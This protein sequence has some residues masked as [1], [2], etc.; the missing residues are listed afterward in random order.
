ML[1]TPGDPRFTAFRAGGRDR[2]AAFFATIAIVTV[3]YVGRD[4]FVPVAVAVLL[5]FVL[6]PVI[7]VLR[8]L[9][10]PRTPAVVGVVLVTFLGLFALGGV[11]ATQVTDLVADLPQYRVNLREK[12]ASVRDAAAGSGALER[13]MDVLQDLSREFEGQRP[14]PGG[15]APEMAV[16]GGEARPVPVEVRQ[17]P[18]GVFGTLSAVLAPLLRPLATFGIVFIF[19]LFILL[20]REDLRNRF[21]RLAGAHDIQRT[22]AALDDAAA[23]LSRFL[24]AQVAL[25]AAFGTV[26]GLGLF[27]I[28]LPSPFLWG[29]AA[30][31]LRFVPYVGAVIA[32]ALP[33]GLALAV[34]PGWSMVLST[35]ALFLVVEPLVG[36]VIE[37]LLYGRSTGLSPAAVIGAATFWTWLWGPVGLLLST[38]LTL[39]LV[40][41][42]R[43]VES[44]EFL[45]VALGDQPPLSDSELLYQRLLAGDPLEAAAAAENHLKEQAP[46]SY[47]DTVALPALRLAQSDA[48]RGALDGSRQARLRETLADMLDHLPEPEAMPEEGVPPA[49]VVMAARSPL[50]EAAGLLLSYVLAAEGIACEVRAPEMRRHGGGA[51]R[52]PDRGSGA[53]AGVEQAVLSYLSPATPAHRRYM[54]RR[55]AREHAGI[56][57][58]VADWAAADQPAGQRCDDETAVITTMQEALDAIRGPAHPRTE[59]APEPTSGPV[60]A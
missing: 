20:Q 19:L 5:A 8:R 30:A 34:D 18:P 29:L 56:A 17:P 31:V 51:G 42:G 52:G 39:C 47:C 55:L 24:L 9:G 7:L 6:A 4:V 53:R 44:L 45:D 21:I 25:N 15:A 11:L 38:P 22:T 35:A 16:A 60:P 1:Q 14:V 41:M 33:L 3:L 46:A 2:L 10:L 49:V 54:I 57:V 27:A 36:H 28:G 59:P 13:T 12:I 50:D 40:V 37:P 32:A 48:A 23:R 58:L 43:H 26:I